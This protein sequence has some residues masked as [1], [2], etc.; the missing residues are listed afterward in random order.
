MC[1]SVAR[2]FCLLFFFKFRNIISSENENSY[3]IWYLKSWTEQLKHHTCSLS[4]Q[5][6]DFLAETGITP[7]L[8]RI[9]IC[10]LRDNKRLCVAST[11]HFHVRGKII[12]IPRLSK[13]WL[14]G[15]G[16]VFDSVW[17]LIKNIYYKYVNLN[18]SFL[19]E[20]Y[21]CYVKNIFTWH[22]WHIVLF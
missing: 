10:F 2:L 11:I 17:L 6:M 21:K 8:P 15:R 14:L 18:Y 13:V 16:C 19:T 1:E 9:S 3:F 12:V 22:F 4:R 5:S 20:N 7:I